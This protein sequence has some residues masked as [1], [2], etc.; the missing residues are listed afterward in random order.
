[1]APPPPKP[2]AR[3][4]PGYGCPS[5]TEDPRSSD[6]LLVSDRALL[7]AFRR[8][9]RDALARVFRHYVDDVATTVRAGV[10]VRIDGRPT[11]V[12]NDLPEVEREA[13]IQET[14]ARAFQ[15]KAR[16]RYDGVRPYGAWLCTIA[17]NLMIDRARRGKRQA[18]TVDPADLEE[19]TA[20]AAPSPERS[21]ESRELAS[22]L[23]AFVEELGHEEQRIFRARYEDR[24]SLREAAR[25]LG[26]PLIRVRRIDARVRRDLLQELRSNGYLRNARVRIPG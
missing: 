5:V 8:G 3:K 2:A 23:Q 22:L 21:V 24:L 10:R 1:M 18:I 9:E 11:R 26:M 12:G 16:E 15:P 6:D 17:R 14:F 7:D 25:A 20:S 4:R 13:I 19:R